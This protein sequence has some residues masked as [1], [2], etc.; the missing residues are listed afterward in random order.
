MVTQVKLQIMIK[1]TLHLVSEKQL[2]LF[3]LESLTMND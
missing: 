1:Q 2:N 3:W